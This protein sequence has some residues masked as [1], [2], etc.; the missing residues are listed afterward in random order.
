MQ[1]PIIS[2]EMANMSDYKEPSLAEAD[3]EISS[4]LLHEQERQ[5]K[6]LELIAS[7]VRIG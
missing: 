1:L 4:I 6:G 3:P 2:T 5:W 7:E